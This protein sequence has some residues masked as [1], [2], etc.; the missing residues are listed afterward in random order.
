MKESIGKNIKRLRKEN[1]MTQEELA[2][3]LNISAVAVS[4]WENELTMPDISQIIPLAN[5]FK[6]T[7][8]ELFGLVDVNHEQEITERLNE[9]FRFSDNIKDGKE[10]SQGLTELEMYRNLLK[11]YPNNSTVLINA[12]S[13][14]HYLTSYR[15][16][17]LEQSVGKEELEK[18][19]DESIKWCELAIKY[20][21]TQSEVFSAKRQL[22]KFYADQKKFD[23][24][25]EIVDTF[26]SDINDV[27]HIYLADLKW[28]AGQ[29]QEQR[30]LHCNNIKS[31]SKAL[32]HQGIMLGNTY[33]D[34]KRYEDALEC[35]N[36]VNKIIEALFN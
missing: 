30:E 2:E 6:V 18:L 11:I 24:A 1:E 12:A 4:K 13:T 5:I 10:V 19:V 32:V 23:K 21:K 20:A 31:L 25:F 7:T 15:E 3:A 22:V 27:K 34:E 35:Y 8:D 17:Q 9:I 26:V 28:M 29:R 16:K 14:G 33:M 36:Y